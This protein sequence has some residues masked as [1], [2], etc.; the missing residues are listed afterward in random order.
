M[1]VWLWN[2]RLAEK[3]GIRLFREQQDGLEQI[4]VCLNP[5][6]AALKFREAFGYGKAKP[7]SFRIS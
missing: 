2:V 5:H 4:S 3:R 7:A 6:A 1:A